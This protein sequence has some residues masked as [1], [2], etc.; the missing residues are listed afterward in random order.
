MLG[1]NLSSLDIV[2]E[3][4]NEMAVVPEVCFAITNIFMDRVCLH[5]FALFPIL[6]QNEAQKP[7]I[8][9]VEI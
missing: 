3:P 7:H 8:L 9:A 4:Y 6:L 5:N 1:E 2:L